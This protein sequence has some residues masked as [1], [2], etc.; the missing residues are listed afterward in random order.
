MHTH[1]IN[2]YHLT[3]TQAFASRIQGITT[4]IIKQ[5]I[6]N[7]DRGVILLVDETYPGVGQ[8]EHPIIFHSPGIKHARVAIDV[9][10]LRGNSPLVKEQVNV[11][12]RRAGLTLNSYERGGNMDL[13]DPALQ[14][15]FATILVGVLAKQFN[16]DPVVK[17][18]LTAVAGAYYYDITRPNDHV[19]NDEDIITSMKSVVRNL[20]VPADMTDSALNLYQPGRDLTSLA[21]NIKRVEGTDRTI[22]LT[23]A[24]LVNAMSGLWFGVNSSQML[25]ICLEHP[26]TWAAIITEATGEGSYSRSELAK[27]LKTMGLIRQKVPHLHSVVNQIMARV[28]DYDQSNFSS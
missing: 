26:A 2:P 22:G 14:I 23:P 1:N 15:A 20:R 4:D 25:A 9:R 16:L 13:F 8:F 24:L 11:L 21:E 27:R 17:L 10:Q 5:A 19:P 6:V 3:A 28:E 12:R 7:G 18:L